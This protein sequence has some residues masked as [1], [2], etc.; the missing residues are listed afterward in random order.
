M[1][2]ALLKCASI[3]HTNVYGDIKTGRVVCALQVLVIPGT[4]RDNDTIAV[5][6]GFETMFTLHYVLGD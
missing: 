3:T 2:T 4:G 5:L 1:Q 6:V